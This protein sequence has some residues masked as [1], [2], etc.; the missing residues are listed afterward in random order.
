VCLCLEKREAIVLPSTGQPSLSWGTEQA[1]LFLEKK[2]SREQSPEIEHSRKC[3][4]IRVA[5]FLCFLL[6][7]ALRRAGSVVNL[8]F[9]AKRMSRESAQNS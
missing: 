1:E 8:P 4:A 9:P 3:P 7:A 6:K 5:A 2:A